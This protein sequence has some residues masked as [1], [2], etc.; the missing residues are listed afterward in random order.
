MLSGPGMHDDDVGPDAADAGADAGA[1]VDAVADALITM[2]TEM[3]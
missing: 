1:D 2:K 3:A